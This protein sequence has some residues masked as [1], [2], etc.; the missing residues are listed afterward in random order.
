MLAVLP[1]L[2][3]A[4]VLLAAGTMIAFPFAMDTIVALSGGRG[5]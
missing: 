2:A 3:A 1:S 5:W 4:A